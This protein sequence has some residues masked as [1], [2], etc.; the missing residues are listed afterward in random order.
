[1]M[2]IDFSFV[3][4]EV[5]VSE[6]FDGYLLWIDVVEFLAKLMAGSLLDAVEV[7]VV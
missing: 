7:D 2:C 6:P 4:A 5:V 1:M 3:A